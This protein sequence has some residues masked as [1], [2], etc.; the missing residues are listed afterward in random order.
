MNSTSIIVDHHLLP[1]AD[2]ARFDFLK[3]YFCELVASAD[4]VPE[5]WRITLNRPPTPD[6]YVDPDF[7]EGL[8]WWSENFGRI[9]IED[10]PFA[11]HD[12][13]GFQL[14]FQDSWTLYS[15]S[16]YLAG[17]TDSASL[18]SEIIVLHLDD[19]DD[20]MTPR[21]LLS[22]QGTDR[23]WI[24]AI[25]KLPFD[26]RNPE[27]VKKAIESGAIGIGSFLAPLLHL[28]PRVHV[29]HLCSTEYLAERIGAHTI[30]IET[31]EDNLLSPGGL[32]P[33][34][35]HVSIGPNELTP[36]GHTYLV[37]DDLNDWLGDLPEC[38]VLVHIDM[39]YFNNRYNGDSDWIYNGAKYDSSPVQVLNR[40]DEVFAAFAE[41]KITGRIVD[42]AA[43]LS[44]GFFPA[45]LWASAIERIAAHYDKLLKEKEQV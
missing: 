14:S 4:Q 32:R 38:P 37:T 23:K 39:D 40:V 13:L 21:L 35:K 17:F 28:I 11:F 22:S 33:A 42:F 18:P 30:G 3:D 41:H 12:K 6:Y 2:S 10:V 15:W 19:H 9:G 16:K 44:P 27:T 8:G 34:I 31:V 1:E 36:S 5:G 45:D 29:R 7:E 26:L 24:D 25:T 43:A 20:F